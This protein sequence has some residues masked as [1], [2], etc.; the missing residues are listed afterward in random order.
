[1]ATKKTYYTFDDVL[2]KPKRSNIEPFEASLE[3]EICKGIKLK[4]PFLSAA[5][6]RVTE[7]EMGIALGRAGALGVVHRNNTIEAQVA[8]V[9]KIKAAGVLAGAAC[10]PFDA[11][12]AKA[13]DASKCDVLVIDCAH[14]HNSKVLK[15]A[16][17][18][19]KALK[20]AKVILGNIATAEAAKDIIKIKCA[21]GIK[22][23]VGPGS[24]CTTRIV[25]GVGV[26]QLSAVEEIAA[27]CKKAK[28][29]VIAD[30]GIRSS[31]DI[32]KALAAGASGVMLGSM[33][34]GCVE[35]PGKRV[36]KN[37]KTYK[38]Y[39]GM[40]SMAVMNESKSSDRYLV[41]NRK[42][43]AE[44]IEAL[45][46]VTTTAEDVV[47]ELASGVQVSMGY[48]GAKTIQ[49]MQKNAEFIIISN[50]GIAESRPHTVIAQ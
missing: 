17:G 12:R 41:K 9:K 4:H 29:P 46:P 6:D 47:A 14:G 39:R 15:S 19:K 10:G 8:I 33:F 5:M 22:V 23:G 24:I 13:L 37:G 21:D 1:M 44:G 18:I 38:E 32:A 40:G 25:S 28:M 48:L 36:E 11:E 30:G 27:V 16:L 26:P 49:E 45:V 43:V 2:L 3:S 34:A 42:K 31:G 35:S 20:H 50:A 7:D